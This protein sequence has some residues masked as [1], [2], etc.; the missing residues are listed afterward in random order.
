M[1]NLKGGSKERASK[2][3]K[4][5]K[6]K[7][8]S[9]GKSRSKINLNDYVTTNKKEC[10]DFV[11]GG[12]CSDN[13]I[14]N[15][16]VL[17]F[18]ENNKG[19]NNKNMFDIVKNEVGRDVSII[20]DIMDKAKNK[21]NCDSE[22]CVV[23]HPEF[24]KFVFHT[25]LVSKSDLENNLKKR[26]KIKG[27]KDNTN[28]LSNYDIDKTLQDWACK[29][30][31]FFPCPFAMI[32]F[33]RTNDPLNAYNLADIYLGKYSKNTTLG[34]IKIP[35]R[36]FGCAI[37][38]DVSSG[39][40][41]HWMA[42]FVDMRGP[43]W[44]IEFFNSAGNGPQKSIVRWMARTKEYL[45]TFIANN[46]DLTTTR[47]VK[48]VTVSSLEHQESNTECGLYTLFYIRC[49]L[50]NVPYSRFLEGEEIPDES[51]MEFRKHCFR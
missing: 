27:P 7:R 4:R 44:T 35:C 17:A 39:S 5:S 2:N 43:E 23:S 33:D 34:N 20:E 51:M 31:D 18:G 46:K 36:T 12:V 9:G 28:W 11:D 37:N 22:S 14:L 26:F 29:F 32:D 25:H 42:I 19:F 50:E 8:S 10:S 13:N 1:E 47:P 40:G 48:I 3:V 38:T 24:K 6:E 16:V 15:A 30:E 41:K 45:D 21:L 49:R